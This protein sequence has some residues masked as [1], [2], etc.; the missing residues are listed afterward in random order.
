MEI[1]EPNGEFTRVFRLQL[2]ECLQEIPLSDE[3]IDDVLEGFKDTVAT[4]MKPETD[5]IWASIRKTDAK[6][7]ADENQDLGKTQF[8]NR[9]IALIGGIA[10]LIGIAVYFKS[11]PKVDSRIDRIEKILEK[12]SK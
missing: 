12:L 10:A 3:Q 4:V 1:F 9:V 11:E 6:I 2:K 7:R 5:K 8:V